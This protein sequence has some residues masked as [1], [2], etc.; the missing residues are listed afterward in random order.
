MRKAEIEAFEKLHIQ[1][2]DMYN[3][4]SILS[5]KTPNTPINEF[6]L[7]F[8]NQLLNT[9]NGILGDDYKPFNDFDLFSN[10]DLPFIS[11]TVLILSQYIQCM[12]KFKYDNV[13]C[14]SGRWYWIVSDCS[15]EIRTARPSEELIH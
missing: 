5:K 7:R 2:K 8:V 13:R 9:A 14:L 11:D 12:E 1:I 10:D 4:M 15:E 3:E 6:K